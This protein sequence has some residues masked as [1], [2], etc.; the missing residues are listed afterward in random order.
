[1]RHG[2]GI[3]QSHSS[4]RYIGSWKHDKRHGKGKQTYKHN[5]VYSGDWSLGWFHGTGE[6]TQKIAN[7][8]HKGIIYQ[9]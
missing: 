3:F 9:I 1:M 7:Q 6:M 4:R 2:E 8:K 5:E